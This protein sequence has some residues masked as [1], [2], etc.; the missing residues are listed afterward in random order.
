MRVSRGRLVLVVVLFVSLAGCAAVTDSTTTNGDDPTD[1]PPTAEGG[2][3]VTANGTLE[4]HFINVGQSA[5]TLLITPTGETMLIDSGDWPEEGEYVI[6][7]L[8]EIGIDR[9]DHL[10]TSHADADHI[11]GHAAV[12]EYFKTEGEGVGAV[13]DPGLS[14]SSNTYSRYLDA[15]EEYDVSLYQTR[16]G[17]QMPVEGVDVSVLGPPQDLLAN[18][19]RNENSLVLRVTHG[20][21]SFLFTGD[22]EVEGES[23]LVQEYGNQ[24]DSTVFKAGHHG[25]RSSSRSSLLDAVQPQVVVVTSA[26]DSQYGHPHEE[27]LQRFASRS[28][29]TY[30]TATHGNVVV[31][32]NGSAVSIATQNE[33]PT[34]PTSLRSGDLVE[35]GTYSEAIVRETIVGSGS[36]AP[37]TDIA[38]DGGGELSLVD[39]N[40]DAEGNDNENLNDEYV[41]LENSGNA[42][43][44]LSGWELVDEAGKT[45]AFPDG[46]TLAPGERVTIHSG[47]GTDS[48][49]DLYWGQETAVWNNAG[50]TVIVRTD[51]GTVV[52]EESY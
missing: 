24:L 40:A 1:S 4:V 38:T 3:A 51:D 20:E 17:A 32:S 12:I 28:I 25:S 39:I 7:Y 47:S 2:N 44:D 36:V 14:S 13:Y 30:W 31:Y 33:A 18:D 46:F 29:P 52:I 15:I 48:A 27:A 19:Q 41:V 35:P 49:T 5:S 37:A 11:G 45:F 9:I 50:D 16:E 6:N 8:Q 21:T 34:D 43:L 22:A 23:A 42:T 10:V 26:Y